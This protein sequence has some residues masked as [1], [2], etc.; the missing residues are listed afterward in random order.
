MVKTSLNTVLHHIMQKLRL[1]T[2]STFYRL[3]LSF[4]FSTI[5]QLYCKDRDLR[6]ASDIF[7]KY[8]VQLGTHI[9]WEVTSS[10]KLF[11]LISTHTTWMISYL[12]ENTENGKSPKNLSLVKCSTLLYHESLCNRS[13]WATFPVNINCCIWCNDVSLL[14]M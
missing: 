8:N 14:L 1:K 9:R 6:L 10:T 5:W 7:Q 11:C 2:Y 4:C 12:S 13:D 3:I